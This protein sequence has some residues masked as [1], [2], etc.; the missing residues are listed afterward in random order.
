MDILIV[1]DDHVQSEELKR[2]L[3]KVFR[4]TKIRT[5]SSES[6]FLSA[7]STI[8]ADPPDIAILDVML[9]WAMP[10]ESVAGRENL[11][12]GN[13][14]L[15]GVRCLELLQANEFTRRVPVILTSIGE[16]P[17]R[18]PMGVLYLPKSGNPDQLILAIRS[19][20]TAGGVLP[21]LVSSFVSSESAESKGG[22]PNQV[23]VS[24]SH[25]DQR[26]L[27]D[28]L[29]H[30]KPLE[31]AGR[32]SAWSD[33]QIKPGGKWFDEI[34]KALASA[35]IAVL[36]VSK[37]FLASDFIQEHELGPLLRQAEQGGVR[38]MWV[39]VRACSYSET[40]LK[41]YQAMISPDKPLAE[42]KAERDRAWVT[43]CDQIRSAATTAR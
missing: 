26:F 30:L 8:I 36:L 3:S 39:P 2:S 40:P 5:I 1:E 31:R 18:L 38:I 13:P 32:I 27:D 41:N 4:G 37:D 33:K 19:I 9:R 23:F 16:A 15:A 11:Q 10:G 34:S 20:L 12:P 35:K 17:S 42:M 14:M 6:G 28:L 7:F 43:I 22:E 21:P 25:K 24:Y 29:A